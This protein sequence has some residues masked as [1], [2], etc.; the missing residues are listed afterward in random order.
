MPTVTPGR[1]QTFAGLKSQS[2][3]VAMVIEHTVAHFSIKDMIPNSNLAVKEQIR[4]RKRLVP[5]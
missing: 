3:H 5:S 2:R 1:L 4:A